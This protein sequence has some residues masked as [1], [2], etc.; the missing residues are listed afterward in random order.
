VKTNLPDELRA[1][2]D[3][4]DGR[5]L[6][7]MREAEPSYDVVIEKADPSKDGKGTSITFADGLGTFL[8]GPEVKAGDVV[9]M[10]DGGAEPML[11]GSRHGWALNGEL[12]EWKTPFERIAE[13]VA[14][15]AKHD[16]DQ[17]ERVERGAEKRARDYDRLPAPLRARLDR[18]A[19]ARADF[20][21]ESGD[22]ELFACVEA[23]KIADHL[24]PRVEAGEDP[25]A[26][27]VAFRD[28]PWEE[29]GAVVSDQHS[30]N[31]FGGACALARALLA[32][33]E[34]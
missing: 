3:A 24:R 33:Q 19:A 13:R 15:L 28:L 21:K 22:Y 17:R 26:V 30:G 11:G 18:F 23:A 31:T 4:H 10:W 12:V 1:V 25:V 32:G 9:T 20:W 5:T 14:W 16:R 8:T 34:V 29:Q 27:V 6:I 7:E 2:L